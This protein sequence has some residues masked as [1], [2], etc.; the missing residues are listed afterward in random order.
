MNSIDALKRQFA[1][2]Q[3]ESVLKVLRDALVEAVPNGVDSKRWVDEQIG[4]VQVRWHSLASLKDTAKRRLREDS[5]P[6]VNSFALAR[7]KATQK[8][9]GVFAGDVVLVSEPEPQ[10]A[11]LT[12]FVC[13]Y[14][15]QYRVAY[16]PAEDFELI[17]DEV[18]QDLP[19]PQPPMKIELKKFTANQKFSEETLMFRAEVWINGKKAGTVEN[20]GRGGSNDVHYSD[21]TMHERVSE[22]LHAL[23]PDISTLDA[24][25]H[26]VSETG[27]IPSAYDLTEDYFFG[28]LAEAEIKKKDEARIQKWLAKQAEKIR[29]AGMQPRKFTIR[30]RNGTESVTVVPFPNP[31][32]AK[33]IEAE[34]QRLSK[35]G[36][37][38]TGGEAL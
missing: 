12:K 15:R 14:F 6:V 38:V 28:M 4:M 20:E 3:D 31:C 29:A 18:A 32:T 21:P 26:P 9:T 8:Y 10:T 13:R 1:I 23:P 22:Y 17:T 16:A 36:A 25:G 2:S 37:V 7:I 11:P 19:T 30:K 35:G 24:H 27:G 33:A 5:G 34:I